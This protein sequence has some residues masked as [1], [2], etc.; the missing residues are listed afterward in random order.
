MLSP[1]GYEEFLFPS[2][3]QLADFYGR[4]RYYHSCGNLTPFLNTLPRLRNLT[5]LHVSSWTDLVT[6]C[7]KTDPRVIL[8]KV[9]HPE[10]DVLHATDE[11]IEKQIEVIAAAVPDRNLW[12]CADALYD[13]DI[14]KVKNWLKIAKKVVSRYQ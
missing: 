3:K 14:E 9:M 7:N 5:M 10:D 8:Q 6:A 12:I 11:Q 4:V 13:G 2:E 1:E